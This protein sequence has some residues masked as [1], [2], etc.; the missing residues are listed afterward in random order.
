MAKIGDN[1]IFLG[2]LIVLAIVSFFLVKPFLTAILAGVILAYLLYPVCDLLNKKIKSRALCSFIII[3]AIFLLVLLPFLVLIGTLASNNA[4]NIIGDLSSFKG[5]FS[6][7]SIR[8]NCEGRTDFLCSSMVSVAG[9]LEAPY[10]KSLIESGLTQLSGFV[11]ERTTSLILKIPNIILSIFILFFILYYLLKDG[12]Q[13]AEEIKKMTPLGKKDKET[14]FK[15]LGDVVHATIY[16]NIIVGI[17]QGFIAFLGF[18]VL[19][20]NNPLILGVLVAFAAL[21]PVV[22]TAIVWL[23][24]SLYAILI[25][26][27]QADSSG[28]IKGIIMI[29]WGALAVSTIDNFIKPKVIG[30]RTHL[31]PAFIL[32]GILGGIIVFGFVG[33]II[34]PVILSALIIFTKIYSSQENNAEAKR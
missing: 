29:L 6:G 32:I 2:I 24:V 18:W 12:A 5:S 21:I 17:L 7:T 23:P 4:S 16:G 34:G 27:I 15:E 25:G 19:G 33:I 26:I 10:A 8:A 22:G 28:I 1:H 13:F 20:F 9:L 31:H 11:I 14:L 30:S 3:L